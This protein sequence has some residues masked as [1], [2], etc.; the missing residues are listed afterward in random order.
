MTSEKSVIIKPD[1]YYKMLVHVLRFGNK[2]R[3][4][5]QFK[6]VM[7]IL[8]GHLEGEPDKKGIRDMVIED[9]VPISHGGAIEVAFAP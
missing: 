1:A 4:R 7:G 8:I 2:A 9:A 3:D 6:E 5:R